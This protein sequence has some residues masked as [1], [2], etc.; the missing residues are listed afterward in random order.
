MHKNPILKCATCRRWLL[1]DL[2]GG[3]KLKAVCLTIVTCGKWQMLVDHVSAT[4]L[5]TWLWLVM[6]TILV[7]TVNSVELNEVYVYWALALRHLRKTVFIF[8]ETSE[9][10]VQF[11]PFV[12]HQKEL[13]LKEGIFPFNPPVIT[14]L[15]LPPCGRASSSLIGWNSVAHETHDTACNF[16]NPWWCCGEGGGAL[17]SVGE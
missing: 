1:I 8:S 13:S 17:K 11:S 9:E 6:V 14:R 16:A 4:W 15:Q 5:K 12:L 3:N 10:R 2:I 7:K